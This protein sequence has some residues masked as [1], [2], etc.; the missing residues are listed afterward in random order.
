MPLDSPEPT[1]SKFRTQ[2]MHVFS[3]RIQTHPAKHLAVAEITS[4]QTPLFPFECEKCMLFKK[5]FS[6]TVPIMPMNTNLVHSPLS[7]DILH[8]I[9]TGQNGSRPIYLRIHRWKGNK[10][11]NI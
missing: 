4:K 1:S 2:A 11:K 8:C 9:D 10:K 5:K 3:Q 7:W 6:I